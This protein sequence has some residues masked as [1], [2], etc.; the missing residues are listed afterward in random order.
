MK[1]TIFDFLKLVGEN[2][3]L[4]RGLVQLAAEHGF[5]FSDELNEEELGGISGG[6][7]PQTTGDD[8]QLE[9]VDMQNWLQKQQQTLQM[10]S[11][12]SRTVHDTIMTE[13]RNIGE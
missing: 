11:T 1:G 8:E 4:A 3:E 10:M 9:A 5:E 6:L 12:L 7:S 2:E 13:I